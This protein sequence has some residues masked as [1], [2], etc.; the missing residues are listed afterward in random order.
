MN[1]EELII[2]IFNELEKYLNVKSDMTIMTYTENNNDDII[3]FGKYQYY[4]K[5][6][7]PIIAKLDNSI[8]EKFLNMKTISKFKLFNSH[9]MM[10]N[11]N[12]DISYSNMVYTIC[13][14]YIHY[15]QL[16]NE[17]ENTN[18]ILSHDSI[19]WNHYSTL[20]GYHYDEQNNEHDFINNSFME[21][22][23]TLCNQ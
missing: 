17:P 14:E 6:I 4:T 3:I 1:T 19:M 9:Y 22:L 23:L 16:I 8:S 7:M 13:H 20:I 15:L 18:S 11:I 2:T 5:Q 12:N 21:Q 10:I